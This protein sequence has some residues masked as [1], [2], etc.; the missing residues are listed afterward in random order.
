MSLRAPRGAFSPTLLLAAAAALVLVSACVGPLAAPPTP[1]AGDGAVTTEDRTAGEFTAISAGAGLNVVIATG[2][3][4]KVTLTAQA[5]LQPYVST[6]VTDGQLV[7]AVVPPGISSDQPITLRVTAPTLVSL[8]LGEGS[9]GTMEARS[10][11]MA[12]NLSGGADLKAIGSVGQ[13]ALTATGGARAELGDLAVERCTV[14]M[15][16]GAAATLRV[17]AT[18]SGTADSGATIH[19]VVTPATQTVTTSGGATVVGG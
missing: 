5:N 18:L 3:P 2:T 11:V 14:A 7:V 10:D 8:S 17:S 13:L 4:T 1:V 12:I 15:S 19:L 6:T 16:G 9:T